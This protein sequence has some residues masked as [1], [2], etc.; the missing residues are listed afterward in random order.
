MASL[1]PRFPIYKERYY[2]SHR[3]QLSDV[4]ATPRSVRIIATRLTE[5]MTNLLL[6]SSI[7]SFVALKACKH[8]FIIASV[9]LVTILFRYLL[10]SALHLITDIGENRRRGS[11]VHMRTSAMP[12][13]HAKSRV[14][15][16]VNKHT[17]A[18]IRW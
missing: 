13:P 17:T 12:R 1:S 15:K 8:L 6:N 16:I 3:Q 4:A 7:C 11:H 10:L 9:L 18:R 14:K 5:Q 2:A